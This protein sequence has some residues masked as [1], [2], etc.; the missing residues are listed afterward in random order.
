MKASLR[1]MYWVLTVTVWGTLSFI[2]PDFAESA[3]EGWRSLATLAGYVLALGGATFLLCYIFGL[4]KPLSAVFLPLYGIGGAVVSYYR[5]AYHATIT[6]MVVEATLHTN[7][8][9][10]AGVTD[11][12]LVL[13]VLL[14]AGMAALLIWWRWRQAEPPYKWVHLTAALMLWAVYYFANGR[15]HQ[16][17][18]QRYPYNVVH[19]LTEYLRVRQTEAKVR[20]V[21]P[22]AEVARADSMD[23]VF[24][25]GEA[26]RGD[27]LSLNGYGRETCPRLAG[28][29]GV[30]SLAKVYSPYSYTSAS[31]PYLMTPADSLHP[32]RGATEH[33]FVHTF[34][35]Y[36]YRTAWLS[37][38]DLGRTY[39][40]FIGEADTVVFP[41][42]DKSVF[43]FDPW[44]D[45][46][47]LPVL[48]GIMQR[49][50]THNLYVLHAI[51][52]HWYY[53]IHVPEALQLFQP[54]TT[55]RVASYNTIDELTNAYDNTVLYADFFLD[56][57]IRRFE[58]RCA[59]LIYLSD[60]GE[61][62]G[63]AGRYL[64]SNAGEETLHTACVLWFS[65]RYRTLYPERV[66]AIR[67]YATAPLNTDFLFPTILSAA[68]IRAEGGGTNLIDRP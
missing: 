57:L 21:W 20:N 67:Q 40:A 38:Q 28:R 33:S 44:Y 35:T 52:S 19:S 54:V 22:T 42:A 45:E 16:S 66:A 53:N 37:N 2:V 58:D 56:S 49:A 31:V 5:M 48:D 8:G 46:E 4:Y 18:N 24:V 62:L 10:I 59:V 25:L 15:L 1:Y 7:A 23:V 34:Q 9:T 27:H 26:L 3:A 30:V 50:G 17:I 61:S 14:H 11:W 29:E 32:E 64:H 12:R 47:L 51:G 55:N 39:A 60:H 13:W 43:V 36:G 65:P 63:E 41:N 68:G 6:P